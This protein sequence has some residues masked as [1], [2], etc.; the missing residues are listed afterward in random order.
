MKKTGRYVIANVTF[1]QRLVHCVLIVYANE[2]SYYC[3]TVNHFYCDMQ[4]YA[5][6]PMHRVGTTAAVEPAL[7]E[8]GEVR[9]TPGSF[10]AQAQ[11]SVTSSQLAMAIGGALSPH[12]GQS[13]WRVATRFAS[14]RRT[15][16]ARCAR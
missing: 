7:A 1:L 5:R 4:D 16:H 8:A 13:R 10:L 15:S 11:A 2:I 6:L 9:R 12:T 3:F 14:G